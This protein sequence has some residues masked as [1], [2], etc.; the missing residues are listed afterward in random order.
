[1]NYVPLY[2]KATEVNLVIRRCQQVQGLA[3]FRLKS[4]LEKTR[5]K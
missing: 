4:D 1:M 2:G 5:K 3:Q